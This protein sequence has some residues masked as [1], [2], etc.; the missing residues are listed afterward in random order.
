[1]DRKPIMGN[2]PRFSISEWAARNFCYDREKG[3]CELLH[4]KKIFGAAFIAYKD[5]HHGIIKQNV[6]RL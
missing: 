3:K 1:M 6:N 5:I 2:K 4:I